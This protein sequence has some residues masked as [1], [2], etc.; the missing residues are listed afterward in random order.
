MSAETNPP[1]PKM[2][3]ADLWKE[4]VFTDRKVGTIRR[5][6]PVKADGSPDMGRKALFL[7][8]ASLLTP[9]GSLPLSFEIPADTLDGAVAAY[10]EAVQKAFT[11][12][13]EEL[14]ELRRKAAT[15]IVLPQGGAGLPGAG[16]L[17][18]APGLG[19][20][21]GGGLPPGKLKL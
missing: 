9:A 14:K 19:G 7:G 8:E 20:G 16:G 21:L 15:S 12:T 5:L 2:D 13:M 17:G 6:T 3:A 1:T 18:G 10:G 4:E 11:E